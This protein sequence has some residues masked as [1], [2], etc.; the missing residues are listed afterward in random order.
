MD[1]IY[2]SVDFLG[3]LAQATVALRLFSDYIV[4]GNNGRN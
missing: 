2:F 3:L 4:F 1:L